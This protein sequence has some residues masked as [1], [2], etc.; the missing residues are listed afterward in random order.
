MAH[1]TVKCDECGCEFQIVLFGKMSQ[2][3][4]HLEHDSHICDD[5][6]AR[7]RAEQ[8]AKAAAENAAAGLPVLEGTP[9]Q[10]AWAESIRAKLLAEVRD[11]VRDNVKDAAVAVISAHTSASWWIDNRFEGGRG[12]V[13]DHAKEIVK[14]MGI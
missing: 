7:L 10:V 11:A 6:T 4:W 3:E 13:S 14:Q 9:K 12:L 2:R 8:N 5:C 1:Y